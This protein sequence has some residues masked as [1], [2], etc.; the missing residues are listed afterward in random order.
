MTATQLITNLSLTSLV[1]MKISDLT[2]PANVTTLLSLVNMAKNKLAEDTLLWV[3][4]EIVPLVTDTYT[5]TLSAIPIQIVD[6]FDSNN[7][8]RPRNSPEFFGYYQTS[9]NTVVF[10]NIT[11]GTDVKFNYYTTPTDYIIS[12]E[13]IVP[14][15]LLSAI[16]SYVAS[17]AFKI[18]KADNDIVKSG[19]HMK[20][21]VGSINDYRA[22]SDSTDV[23]TV[24][25]MNNRIWLRGLK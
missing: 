11:N 21:Y 17:K 14:H 2:V 5:Y 6:A 4:G 7:N 10:N 25:S 18:Y 20:E 9:P 8:L 3:G 13:L 22:V 19:E 23:D 1:G 12:D 24:V 16:E 15:T